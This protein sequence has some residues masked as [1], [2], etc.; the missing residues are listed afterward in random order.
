MAFSLIRMAENGVGDG[1]TSAPVLQDT[2][3]QD[4]KMYVCKEI[5]M[6]LPFSFSCALFIYIYF[7]F[8]SYFTISEAEH[9]AQKHLCDLSFFEYRFQNRTFVCF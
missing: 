5:H 9:V 6:D 4:L 8:E 7:R 1:E 2:S 3:Q